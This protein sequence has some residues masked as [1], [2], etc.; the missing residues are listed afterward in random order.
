[1][2]FEYNVA[3]KKLSA[4]SSVASYTEHKWDFKLIE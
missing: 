2:A 4:W 3:A 1:M